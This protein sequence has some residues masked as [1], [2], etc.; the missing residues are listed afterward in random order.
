M[1]VRPVAGWIGA[2]L[3]LA[4]ACVP[5]AQPQPSSAPQTSPSAPKSIVIAMNR[6]PSGFGPHQSTDTNLTPLFLATLIKY[7]VWDNNFE[8]WVATEL[9]SLERGTWKVLPDGRMET[10]WPLRRDVKWHDGIP[11]T[12]RD[13]VFGWG[14]VLDPQFATLEAAVPNRMESVTAR[15]DHT[16]VIVWK[17]IFIYANLLVRGGMTPL[18]RHLLEAD[19]RR[20]PT[21]LA[22]HPYFTTAYVG[23]GPYRVTS[24]DPGLSIRFDASPDY[25]LGKPKID[26]IFYRVISDQ[27]TALAQVLANEVDIT[28]RSA[29]GLNPSLTAKERWEAAGEGNV[30]YVQ[31]GWSN[32]NLSWRNPWFEDVQVRRGM[33]HAIDRQEMVR[34]V[35]FGVTSVPDT[36]IRASDPLFPEVDRRVTKYPYDPNRA[37][38]LMAE[39]GWRPG[40]DGI[41]V[42][43][44]GERLS[45]EA[46]ATLGDR[47]TEQVQAIVLDHWRTLGVESRVNNLSRRALDDADNRGRWPGA[48]FCGAAGGSLE[49]NDPLHSDWHSRY[50]PTEANNW[51]GDNQEGWRAAD[52]ILDLWERELDLAKREQL[53]LQVALRWAEDLPSLPLNFNVEITTVRKGIL[54]ASPRLGSGGSNA[55]TWNVQE[56]DRV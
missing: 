44:R 51:Q 47:E 49:P 22:S 43:G 12:A 28:M 38:Q 13:L 8:P 29:I 56:W 7:K 20:E 42:N 35:F 45:I 4:L 15:D 23:T 53:R 32:V 25:F 2:A 48:C 40:P 55:M 14:V 6:D 19:Y 54:N 5:A 30:H 21:T 18:P 1:I 26:T 31:T 50:I 36:M 3:L 34:T 17:D 11:F 9:P 37:R 39:A 10:V 16:L 27:N 33:L 41:L 46:R 52:A 24:F